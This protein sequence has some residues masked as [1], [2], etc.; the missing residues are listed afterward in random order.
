M[1]MLRADPVGRLHLRWSSFVVIALGNA[2]NG[3]EMV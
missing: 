3:K 2:D 1:D